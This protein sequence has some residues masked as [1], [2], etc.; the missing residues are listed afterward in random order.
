VQ[1]AELIEIN[2]DDPARVY[3]L[4]EYGLFVMYAEPTSKSENVRVTSLHRLGVLVCLVALLSAIF[5]H[6]GHAA[7]TVAAEQ[8]AVATVH[9]MDGSPVHGHTLL[10]QHCTQHVQCSLNAIIPAAP[11]LDVSSAKAAEPAGEPY[12]RSRIVSPLRRPPKP[13]EIL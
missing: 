13:D 12:R 10:P 3:R 7:A 4:Y 8:T 6:L 11:S 1:P 5:A 9:E 2:A